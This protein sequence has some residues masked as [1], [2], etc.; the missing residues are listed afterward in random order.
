MHRRGDCTKQLL[1]SSAE[2]SV[3]FPTRDVKGT[4]SALMYRR[5]GGIKQLLASCTELSVAVLA[6]SVTGTWSARAPGMTV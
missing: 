6:R 2:L 3:A 4:W 5:D 1:A